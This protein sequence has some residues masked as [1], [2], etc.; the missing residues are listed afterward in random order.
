MYPRGGIGYEA[1]WKAS[2]G[3]A[4]K[5]QCG[6]DGGDARVWQ[7]AASPKPP[8]QV[9]HDDVWP[10]SDPGRA[11]GQAGISPAPQV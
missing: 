6:P 1:A 5:K 7:D 10:R 4:R 11:A 9:Q 3:W 8:E 2:G